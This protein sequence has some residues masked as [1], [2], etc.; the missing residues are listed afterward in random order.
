MAYLNDI[1]CHRS[2]AH[3]SSGASVSPPFTAQARGEWRR[4]GWGGAPHVEPSR[5][6]QPE[7]KTVFLALSY[8]FSLDRLRAGKQVTLDAELE[9]TADEM[10]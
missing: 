8:Y 3:P 7:K 1:L 5:V 10:W 6:S 4:I 2:P 9:E